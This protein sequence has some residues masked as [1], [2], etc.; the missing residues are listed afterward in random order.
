MFIGRIGPLALA[1]TL[2]KSTTFTDEKEEQGIMI[3]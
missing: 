3:G 1:Y 2:I